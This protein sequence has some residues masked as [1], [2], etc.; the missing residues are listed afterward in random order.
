MA[1]MNEPKPAQWP[2][3]GVLCI[4]FPNPA[5]SSGEAERLQRL[6]NWVVEAA[7]GAGIQ[8]SEVEGEFNDKEDIV[9]RIY[10]FI[11]KVL[12]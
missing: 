9:S 7:S 8:L 6:R 2:Y 5:R 4:P 10:R 3:Q 12:S 11:S 1:T